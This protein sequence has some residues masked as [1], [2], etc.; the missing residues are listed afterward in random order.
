[1]NPKKSAPRKQTCRIIRAVGTAWFFLLAAAVTTNAHNVTVFAWVDGDT[2]YVES[3]FSGGRTAKNAPIEVL[4]GAGNLILSGKTDEQGKFSFQVPGK[5]EMKVVLHAGMGHKAIWSIP[6]EDLEGLDTLPP[7][8]AAAT[9]KQR[10]APVASPQPMEPSAAAESVGPTALEIEKTV[11]K[12]LDKK[13]KPVL[14]MLADSR[15]SGPDIRDIL[16]GIGYIFGLVGLAAY[17]RYRRSGKSSA[18]AAADDDPTA[19]GN[20]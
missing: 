10:P 6:A 17:L 11:E 8:P 13:L 18:A 1:M 15:P 16:G 4:D 14:K 3:K 19:T 12:V 7:A 5:T 2:V 9:V 20:R